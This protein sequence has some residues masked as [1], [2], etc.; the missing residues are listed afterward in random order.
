M[1][2][3]SCLVQSCGDLWQ[4]TL[5]HPFVK[6]IE[7]ANLPADRFRFY[8]KQD[9][10][11]LIAY[12]RAIA[13]AVYK[14]PNLAVMKEMSA[15]LNS[16]LVVEMELHRNYAREF[17]ITN[18]EFEKEEVAPSMLAYTSYMLDIACRYSF[19]SNIV[20]ILPCALGYTEIG[21]GI[22]NRQTQNYESGKAFN[23]A[24]PYQ[25]WIDMY[26][27]EEFVTYSR[28][29]TEITN[30]LADGLPE[31]EVTNLSVIF[32]QSTRYEWMFWE[33]AWS[34]EHWQV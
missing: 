29:L 26:S 15:L 3:V 6:A 30:E 20:C 23:G 25:D 1:D 22:L 9:Y 16:T 14:A 32:N 10:L 24:N 17:G 21:V 8:L 34:L 28:R 13:L 31:R 5:N 12:S 18:E 11:Y 27:S 7:Q 4:R 33:M 2:F 19:L